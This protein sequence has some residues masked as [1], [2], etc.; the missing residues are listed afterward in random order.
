MVYFDFLTNLISLVLWLCWRYRS[1]GS[2]QLSR[3]SI[4]GN[5]KPAEPGQGRWVF[6]LVLI[7]LI[8]LRGFFYWQLGPDLG[9]N[10]ALSLSVMSMTF[11]SDFLWRIMLY[12]G[13]SFL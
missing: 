4:I 3:V 10:P 9:W 1:R 11:R 5:L 7:A 8:V 6:F 2:I 13:L 12:S